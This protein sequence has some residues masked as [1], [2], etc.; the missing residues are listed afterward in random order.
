LC[1][2]C[3]DECQAERYVKAGGIPTPDDLCGQLKI[4]QAAEGWQLFLVDGNL[5]WRPIGAP[6]AHE[7][8]AENAG[9]AVLAAARLLH[10]D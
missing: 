2:H 7:T 1:R 10:G 8:A 4:Q 9:Q 6:F 3:Y 5:D